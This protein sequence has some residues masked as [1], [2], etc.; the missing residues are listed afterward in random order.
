MPTMRASG[1]VLNVVLTSEETALWKGGDT[2]EAA[3]FRVSIKRP[4]RRLRNESGLSGCVVLDTEGNFLEDVIACVRRVDPETIRQRCEARDVWP[5]SLP[6]ASRYTE[7]RAAVEGWT[8]ED[9]EDVKAWLH[10]AAAAIA[11]SPFVNVDL[12]PT[13][14]TGSAIV[15]AANRRLLA[16]AMG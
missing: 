3:Q 6:P 12:D 16:F 7:I 5:P 8:D 11:A 13:S 9:A 15:A 2:R 14:Y 4:A 1:R 10:E